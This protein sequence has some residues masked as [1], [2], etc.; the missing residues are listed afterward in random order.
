V[1]CVGEETVD[2][3]KLP[4]N[5][6]SVAVGI[7]KVSP[8]MSPCGAEDVAVTT[9]DSRL[10]VSKV[11]EVGTKSVSL[12]SGKATVESSMRT[13]LPAL[14]VTTQTPPETCV[15]ERVAS[16]AVG[17]VFIKSFRY[18]EFFSRCVVSFNRRTVLR[19]YFPLTSN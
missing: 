17:V 16:F 18:V 6:T 1:N 9:P 4:T 5:V 3:T 15:A 11:I 13:R 8:R 2:T 7:E 12:R 19:E 14:T 10:R